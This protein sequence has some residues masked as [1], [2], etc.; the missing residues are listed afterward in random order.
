MGPQSYPGSCLTGQCAGSTLQTGSQCF[1]RLIWQSLQAPVQLPDI[2]LLTLLLFVR[3]VNQWPDYLRMLEIGLL[4]WKWESVCLGVLAEFSARLLLL[5]LL[6]A[7]L[8]FGSSSISSLLG[9]HCVIL[10]TIY[11]LLTEGVQPHDGTCPLKGCWGW[12]ISA[13]NKIFR[14]FLKKINRLN[15]YSCSIS[16]VFSQLWF[17]RAHFL[18]LSFA[19]G[20]GE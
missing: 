4:F 19:V 20:F 7:V 3:D 9:V 8:T 5:L 18:C 11:K 10:R 16:S 14:D 15:L 13:L 12:E 1:I 6:N 2:E 17:Q